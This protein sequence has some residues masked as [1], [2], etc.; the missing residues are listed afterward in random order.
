M[1]GI[2]GMALRAATPA[3]AAKDFSAGLASLRHRGPDAQGVWHDDRVWLGHARLSIIDLSAAGNQPMH[4]TAGRFALV[5]NGE[6]Y[7][8]RELAAAGQ[9]G[10]LRST[11]D[12]EVVLRSFERH[13]TRSLPMF[14]GMFAFAILD[15]V[16]RRLWLVRDRLGIKPLFYSFDSSGLAFASEIKAIHVMRGTH[17]RC[18]VESLHEWLYY[19]NPLGGNTLHDGIAQVPPGHFLEL[20][21]DTFAHRLVPY[22]SLPDAA[23]AAP[24][25][26]P[27]ERGL[28]EHTRT[29]LER[30]VQRQLIADVPVGLFLSGGVDSSALAAFASRHLPGRLATFAAGFDFEAGEGERPRARRVAAAFGTDHHEILIRGGDVGA[31]V[32]E[33]VAHH[34][35]PFGDAAN[36]PLTLMARE[37]GGRIKVVLQG[38]GG[39]E[40]FL[41]YSRYFT[42]AH[43]APLRAAAAL[44]LPL[45]SL[46][47]RNAFHF[48][49]RRYLR[50]LRAAQPESMALLLTSEDRSLAPERVF[51]APVA[52]RLLAHDPFAR[53]RAVLAQLAGFDALNQMSFMDLLITLPDQFLEKVDRA[54]MAASLEVRVPFLDNDLVDFAIG[55]PGA[56]KAPR[57]ER[58]ALLKA[59][60]AGI[61]PDEVLTAPKSG[62]TVPYARW[63]EG[64]LRERFFDHLGTFTRRHDGVLDADHLRRLYAATFGGGKDD[65]YMLWKILNFMTWTNNSNVEFF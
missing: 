8:F 22:W 58:K 46:T 34:D 36:L 31:L 42:M 4:D 32:E 28:I 61:V 11:S 12:T 43:H 6:V 1:C 10:A 37:L 44:L 63:L 17:P 38:D 19:G 64:P 54:T 30:A 40:L 45:Q 65:S 35:M 56:R 52:A 26:P 24:A 47:P 39:D 2:A 53:H 59:A 57:G 55:L 3:E 18:R 27:D 7:N 48:R 60:L 9:F 50:A 13:G 15:R 49:V 62:L 29:L 41:G 51:A 23:R 5:Y 25:P 14:N 20:D 21:L 33:L 16:E